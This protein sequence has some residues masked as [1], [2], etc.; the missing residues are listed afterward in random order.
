MT[1]SED[2][3][4]YHEVIEHNWRLNRSAGREIDLLSAAR[5]Y[6]DTVLEH[7]SDER[8]VLPTIN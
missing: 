4:I 3:E 2:P 5:D 8:T 6:V 7:H 1:G